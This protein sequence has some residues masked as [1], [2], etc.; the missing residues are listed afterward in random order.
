MCT[1]SILGVTDNQKGTHMSKQ[2]TATGAKNAKPKD[3][4]YTLAA[5]EGLYLVVKPSGSKSWSLRY[6]ID[7]KPFKK[8]L[9]KYPALTLEEARL[10]RNAAKA[11]LANGI[12]PFPKKVHKKV[13]IEIAKTFREWAE[14]Y[15]GTLYDDALSETHIMRTIKAFRK[16]V[17]PV[18]G[19]SPIN[20]IMARDIIRILHIMKERGAIESARK[21]F[22]SINRV[23]A[24]AISNY[25][26]DIDRNPTSD[27]SLSDVIGKKQTVSYPIITDDKDL[28]TLLNAIKEYGLGE[29]AGQQTLRGHSSTRLAL[30]ML[31][32]VFTRPSN[33]RLATWEEV[34]LN[35]KQWI[36]PGSKMKTKKELIVPL[37]TQVIAILKE[38]K[39]ASPNSKLIFP[40]NRSITSPFSD[41]A[42]V[43]A[44]RRLGYDRSEIVAHSFRGIFSTITHEKAVYI[45]DVIETQ[46][47]HSVGS[48]VSQAYNRA[49]H[50]EERTEMMQWYSDHLEYIMSDGVQN[51]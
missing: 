16:D 11:D 19:D 33:V 12:D 22:S 36:I 47:A 23:F 17:Y 48:Q 32:H 44:L 18:I 4:E 41:A 8:S 10:K 51:G 9:G 49:K 13:H 35:A 38:A 6:R 31:A 42:M 37:S 26:D 14:W 40:S 15:I 46:L 43:G 2:I 29:Q 50:L 7:A 5:G 3:K 1:F 27:I 34:D 21:T 30:M 28:G 24:K 25:P 45:H 20:D 39:E